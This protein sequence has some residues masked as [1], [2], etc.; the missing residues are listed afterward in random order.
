MNN[1]GYGV[2]G[3]FYVDDLGPKLIMID[4]VCIGNDTDNDGDP[5]SG[6]IFFM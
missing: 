4:T 1:V 6:S 5:E 3:Y 2:L